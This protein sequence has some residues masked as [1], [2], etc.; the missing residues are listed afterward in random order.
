MSESPGSPTDAWAR[1]L[2]SPR[3]EREI[4]ALLAEFDHTGRTDDPGKPVVSM[5]E[6]VEQI[7]GLDRLIASLQAR[8]L[9]A[10][11]GF[12]EARRDLDLADGAPVDS[13]G[14]HAVREIA[15]ARRVSPVT[16][17]HQVVFAETLTSDFPQLLAACLDGSVTSAAAR[18]VVDETAPLT[19]EQRRAIDA[20]VTEDAKQL[21]P[22]QL[23]KASG[24][25]VVEIDP[26]AAA[27]RERVARAKRNV[28]I[29]AHPDG[30]GTLSG[31]LHAEEAVACFDAL[32]SHARGLRADGDERSIS[33][34]MADTLVERITGITRAAGVGVEVGVVISAGSLLGETQQPAVLN[35]YGAISPTLARHLAAGESVFARRLVC[36]PVDGQLIHADTGRRCFD[37]A[38]R[39]FLKAADRGCRMP[40]CGSPIRDLD[41]IHEHRHGG[42]TSGVNG[43]G[44][45]RGC[46]TTKHSSGWMIDIDLPPPRGRPDLTWITPTGHRYRSRPPPALGPG[47]I[48]RRQPPYASPLEAQLR[49]RLDE[50]A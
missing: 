4:R 44:L 37:G 27:K 32:D 35:G 28:R 19:S 2:R 47:S 40:V 39:R 3:F 49:R 24:Y 6:R 21:T 43:Q 16:V 11:N 33:E 45:C 10:V 22:G 34:L 18:V 25:R 23:R 9:V 17:T 26:D 20:A 38:L 12:V 8:Q 13:A 15:L 1:R 7:A 46:H 29:I 36:D 30:V 41:H 42:A 50:A 5:G 31:L 14:K 48:N